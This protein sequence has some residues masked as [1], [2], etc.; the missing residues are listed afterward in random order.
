MPLGFHWFLICP[1]VLQNSQSCSI[2]WFLP[3]VVFLWAVIPSDHTH[4]KVRC[5]FTKPS[6]SP[7]V[8][9]VSAVTGQ[10]AAGQ[11]WCHSRTQRRA[12]LWVSLWWELQDSSFLLLNIVY[13]TCFLSLKKRCRISYVPA[14]FTSFVFLDVEETL[15]DVT[16]AQRLE[17]SV[18]P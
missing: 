13:P 6:Q 3:V 9:H 10:C 17:P 16:M 18:L 5:W 12:G 11:P 2:P 7:R 8:L 1:S 14:V 15:S 4:T